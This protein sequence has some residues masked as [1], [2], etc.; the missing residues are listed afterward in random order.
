[1]ISQFDLVWLKSWKRLGIV[2]KKSLGFILLI[3]CMEVTAL[4]YTPVFESLSLS[5]RKG[6]SSGI[7]SGQLM[8]T[9]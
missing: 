6:K 4:I 7:A 3:S 2:T 9:L 5:Q 8:K 1:M